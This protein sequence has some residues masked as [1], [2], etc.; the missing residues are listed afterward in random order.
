MFYLL[1]FKDIIPA[2]M[3]NSIPKNVRD[4]DLLV[5]PVHVLDIAFILPGLIITSILIMKKYSM[6][7]ILSPIFLVF[8]ILMVF[9]LSAMVAMLKVRGVSEDISIAGIFIILAI[10]SLIFLYIF[11]KRIK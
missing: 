11:M 3:E 6:G 1:W 5:N 10:V 8:I 2:I 9:S 4:Y 7:F